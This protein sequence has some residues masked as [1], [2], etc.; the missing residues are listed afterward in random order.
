[1]RRSSGRGRDTVGLEQ[2]QNIRFGQ[3]EA[4]GFEGDF[5]FV[6]VNVVVFVEVEEG[7]L[8]LFV[9]GMRLGRKVEGGEKTQT[10]SLISSLCS[11]DKASRAP[12]ARSSASRRSRSMRSRSC[13]AIASRCPAAPAPPALYVFEGPP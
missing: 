10:A 4:Q 11:S 1:M 8:G 7:E 3:V 12:A 13:R 2:S 6:V 5:E 9:L